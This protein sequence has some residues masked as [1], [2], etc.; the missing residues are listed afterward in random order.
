M[1]L[2]SV[3]ASIIILLSSPMLAH[4]WTFEETWDDADGFAGW[5][6]E[7]RCEP[8]NFTIAVP[9]GDLGN[10]AVRVENRLHTC[11]TSQGNPHA[12]TEIRSVEHSLTVYYQQDFWWCSRIYIPQDWP[13]R[14]PVSWVTVTQI[15]PGNKQLGWDPDFKLTIRA[16]GTWNWDGYGGRNLGPI[17]RG[18]WTTWKI[19]HRRSTGSDGISQAWMNGQL[20]IDYRGKTTFASIEAASWKF[21]IYGNDVSTWPESTPFVL[22]FDDIQ[23]GSE[24]CEG[25]PLG[26]APAPV[27][28]GPLP[29]PTELRIVGGP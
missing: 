6:F 4:A 9:P 16:N 20:V 7:E 2:I 24:R 11:G 8:Y 13:S 22:Y 1:P 12:R 5:K 25:N 19:H 29:A 15:A 28:S 3:L 17:K 10:H 14:M 26:G 21:G 23:V 27:P 18:G